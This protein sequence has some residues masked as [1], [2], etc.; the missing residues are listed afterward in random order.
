MQVATAN[1]QVDVRGELVRAVRV[2]FESHPWKRLQLER[3]KY[4]GRGLA[5]ET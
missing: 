2:R 3:Q 5:A 1:K 4:L